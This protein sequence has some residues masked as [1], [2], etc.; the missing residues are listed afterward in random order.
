MGQE[1]IETA[2]SAPVAQQRLVVES[3]QG[4]R[5]VYLTPLHVAE[6]D[7][8]KRLINLIETPKQL[9]QMDIERAISGYSRLVVARILLLICY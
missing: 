2:I 5:V 6:S 9:I 3:E 7:A 1:V 4:D 8:A